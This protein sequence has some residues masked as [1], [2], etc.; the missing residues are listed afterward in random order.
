MASNWKRSWGVA[1]GGL[2][3]AAAVVLGACGEGDDRPSAAGFASKVNALCEAEHGK[4]DAL[5]ENFPEEPTPQDMQQL[6]VDFTPIVRQFRADVIEVGEPSGKE[7]E[8][9][10]YAELLDEMV[11][12]YEAA[13]QDAEKA[14]AMFNE[15]GTEMADAERDLGLAVC[16]SR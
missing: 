1:G 12:R 5:F 11:E 14:E 4:V 13:G 8:Y 3:A 15:E 6:V 10:R 16:A 2:V 7:A 9:R